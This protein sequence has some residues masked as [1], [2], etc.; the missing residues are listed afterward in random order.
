[1]ATIDL[2][3]RDAMSS[4]IE[5]AAQSLD[6]LANAADKASASATKIETSTSAVLPTFAS[7]NTKLD[8]SAGLAAKVEAANK[9]YELS[10][11]SLRAEA[12]KDAEVA[13]RLHTLEA[14]A[15]ADRDI[16]IK[17]ATDYANNLKALRSGIDGTTTATNAN[18]QAVDAHT[19]SGTKNSFM[20]RQ[21]QIQTVQTLGQIQSGQP[22]FQTLITQ[23]RQVFDSFESSGASMASFGQAVAGML[24]RVFSLPGAI[25]A[26]V[27][28]MGALAVEAEINDRRLLGL[29][30]TLRATRD[31]YIALATEAEAASR[32]LASS[33][34]GISL[35]D[36]RAS[37]TAI[38]SA[39]NF[40][41]T[42]LQLQGL[43][44]TA[45][46]LA[47]EMGITVPEA[48]KQLASALQD[49]GA[50]AQKLADIHFLGMT[51]ALANS[52]KL[53]AQAG[54]AAGAFARELA[55][56]EA[57][58]KGAS[59]NLTP[60]QQS[61][62]GLS[63]AFTKTGSDGKSLSDVLGKAVTD[64]AA[65]A[66]NGITSVINGI[67]RLREKAV[68]AINE[69]PPPSS[70]VLLGPVQLDGQRAVGAAQVN[71][72]TARGLGY[73]DDVISRIEG[74]LTAG[75]TYFTQQVTRTG[76]LSAGSGSYNLGP[77][78]YDNDPS[79]A[80]RY[81]A[82]VD[83]RSPSALPASVQAL[84][85]GQI[86]PSLTNLVE[87]AAKAAGVSIDDV[88]QRF[89]K[90]VVEESGGQ[91]YGTALTGTR[92]GMSSN[93]PG[94]VPLSSAERSAL[95]GTGLGSEGNGQQLQATIDQAQKAADSMG[96]TS[97]S[98]A[99]AEANVKLF[100][101]A[102]DAL[103]SQGVTTGA[104][105]DQFR[106][107]LA[108]S[109]TEFY[110]AIPAVAG[111]VRQ[112]DLNRVANNNLA[113]AYTQND[114]AVNKVIAHNQALL[115]LQ[116]KLAP[117]AA[118][119]GKAVADLTQK[120]LDEAKA[121]GDIDFNKTLAD[122]DKQT[123]AQLR[124][125]AAWDGSAGSLVHLTDVERA[126]AQVEKEGNLTDEEKAR[127]IDELAKG[128]DRAAASAQ[129]FQ[130]QQASVQA[131]SGAFSSAFSTIGNAITQAFVSGQGAAVNWGN[132]VKSVL[133]QVI[134]KVAELAIL[135]PI[136][137][138]L[139]GQQ[140]GT[141]GTGLQTL[142]GGGG[143]TPQQ[144]T[145]T[146]DAAGNLISTSTTVLGTGSSVSGALGGP[147]IQG[148]IGSQLGLTG[149]G[150]LFS[151]G[152]T[153]ADVAAASTPLAAGVAGPVAASG[154]V[155]VGTGA[156]SLGGLSSIL[157]T[158]VSGSVG[159][160]GVGAGTI[161]S[162][163][164]GAAAGFA[165]GSLSGSLI[166]GSL[167]KAPSIN[168]EVGAAIGTGVG[169]AIGTFVF[170][171]IGTALGA[172]LGGALGGSIGGLFGPHKASVF[173]TTDLTVDKGQIEVGKTI[174][175][176]V[177]AYPRLK[178]VV[179]QIDALQKFESE[180]NI[181]TTG[182]SD[183]IQIGINNPGGFQDPTKYGDLNT[184]NV[185]GHS[186]FSLLSFGSQNPIENDKISKKVFANADELG[187]WVTAFDA[188][189]T[190]TQNIISG[191][192][193]LTGQ[194]GVT[195][196]S[197]NTSLKAIN[198]QFDG[199]D[200]T[201][202]A[203]L[204]SEYLSADQTVALTK[205]ENDLTTLR[206]KAIAKVNEQLNSQV[207]AANQSLMGRFLAASA[208]NDNS[209]LEAK[210]AQLYS[211][212]V[213]A[214]QQRL[215]FKNSLVDL[216][217]DGYLATSAYADEV[218]LQE[219]TLGAER[220]SI[221]KSFNDQI[222]AADK[223]AR[224][225]SV[226]DAGATIV[227]LSQY[228]QKLQTGSNSPLSAQ[229]QLTLSRQAFTTDTNK[230]RAGDLSG[231]PSI[232]SDADALLAASR[233]VNG[234]GTGFVGDFNKVL[235]TI[236]TIATI[237]VDTL[238]AGIFAAETKTQTQVLSDNLSLLKAELVAIKLELRQAA[239]IPTQVAA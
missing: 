78:G 218:S 146:T 46:D 195:V 22:I 1:M 81:N 222:T 174:Q 21:L 165:A 11:A 213:Q 60:L 224:D 129:T 131:I 106:E 208:A 161:G 31:D 162:I 201:I 85:E 233:A 70:R 232:T 151:A 116:G 96:L 170:P 223:A 89:E 133:A 112:L 115:D 83:S 122:T 38:V 236:S 198:D 117:S 61:T 10:L 6:R 121:L 77:T 168:P 154:E 173:S 66:V 144:T 126:R 125:N 34:S 157:G 219:K 105:V 26:V 192:T 212:D 27:V 19:D 203:L 90:M 184:P 186:A 132:V 135:N 160:G 220:L 147:T 172:F 48:A 175:Q 114:A 145:T 75:L 169:A 23:S 180:H 72:A 118:G 227:N 134:Q 155:A 20:Q 137:N 71:P 166:A 209:P 52:I 91:Q 2:S 53:Q 102:L 119:Y 199:A 138:S 214:T 104:Q 202:K 42:Q 120:H 235:S 69:P 93:I 141:L 124:I 111:V 40:Q 230:I 211:F 229:D 17:K 73:S 24:G 206:G 103:R 178:A 189:Q 30:N 167:N 163:G 82:G 197:V 107:A 196:G 86:A 123:A 205:A 142:L 35:S 179:A 139:F 183:R 43:V 152:A 128:F 158:S 51:Q 234:S 150:S 177:D 12:L 37:T 237:P 67:Q 49:P 64:A 88:V 98:A 221:Q 204:A 153:A 25:V 4:G 36:A 65:L 156:G 238:T 59:E 14:N 92:A 45:K 148:F 32:A 187:A 56:V 200:A 113:T 210:N 136:L 185:T 171:V 188:A 8:E 159:V 47:T 3:V 99:S 191:T 13:S 84:I 110:D 87:Q 44:K 140:N 50:E 215:A 176:G 182:Q 7:L 16:S 55:I 28:G 194:F 239:N 9:K 190:A 216:Y 62:K 207:D 164:G 58:T 193:S 39:P 5:K 57:N 228:L 79:R 80:T 41:G 95:T 29:Q 101:K 231:L 68:E 94:A 149:P 33:T 54:D 97:T 130:Q 181:A 74:N 127:R 63:E 217:G 226:T 109:N 225:K 100:T 15:A 108:K 76:N 143:G 18:K